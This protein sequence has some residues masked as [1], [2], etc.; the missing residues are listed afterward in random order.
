MLPSETG[1]FVE[2]VVYDWLQS[3]LSV[4]AS[5]DVDIGVDAAV[6]LLVVVENPV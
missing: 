5:I 1:S 3:K 2:E 4:K 6:L